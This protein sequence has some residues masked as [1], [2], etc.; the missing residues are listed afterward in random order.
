MAERI[1]CVTVT[2]AIAHSMELAGDIDQ[3]L[4]LYRIKSDKG[5]E[6]TY[7]HISNE[8]MT[9]GEANFLV[10]AFKAWMF[11]CFAETEES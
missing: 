1:K 10:D 7:G 8:V 2:D 11:G 3:V 9:Q 5:E 6:A 4:I